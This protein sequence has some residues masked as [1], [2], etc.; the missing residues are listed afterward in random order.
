MKLRIHMLLY[1]LVTMGFMISLQHPHTF[2]IQ[3]VEPILGVPLQDDLQII[4]KS[5]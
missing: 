1:L 2:K 5:F 3:S 4:L